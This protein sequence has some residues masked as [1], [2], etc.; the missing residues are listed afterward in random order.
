MSA[1]TKSAGIAAAIATFAHITGVAGH[2]AKHVGKDVRSVV[3]AAVN[4]K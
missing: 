1:V 2:T 4:Q 3:T